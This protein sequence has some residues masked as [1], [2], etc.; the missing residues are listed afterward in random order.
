MVILG[1]HTYIGKWQSRDVQLAAPHLPQV[2]LEAQK[3]TRNSPGLMPTS[4]NFN[5]GA[6]SRP[7][8]VFEIPRMTTHE[9]T[10]SASAGTR[11]CEGG[12]AEIKSVYMLY[13]GLL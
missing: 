9:V 8:Q 13:T 1:N 7:W 3:N 2:L 10:A 4:L 6:S 11:M 12:A 5:F